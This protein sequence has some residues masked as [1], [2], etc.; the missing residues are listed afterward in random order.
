[1]S[2][3]LGPISRRV[4][5]KKLRALGYDGPLSGAKHAFMHKGSHRVRLPNQKEIG[6][7]LHGELLRQADT[8]RDEWLGA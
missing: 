8:S 1:M 5:I 4:V 2:Q 6:P 7:K 3:R